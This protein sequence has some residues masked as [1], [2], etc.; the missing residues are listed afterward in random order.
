METFSILRNFLSAVH[1]RRTALTT[2]ILTLKQASRMHQN[3]PMPDRK[4]NFFSGEGHNPISKP[5]P[6]S[7][8][9]F[10]ASILVLW[11]S[12]FGVP[13]HVRLEHR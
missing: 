12:A 11:R 10:G 13:F 8:G 7:I 6:T 5:L 3:A 4:E 1:A 2:S 9:A